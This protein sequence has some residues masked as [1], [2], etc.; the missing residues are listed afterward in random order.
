MNKI[1]INVCKSHKLKSRSSLDI[2]LTYVCEKGYS[3]KYAYMTKYE[4]KSTW[5]NYV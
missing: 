2:N 3:S 1:M 5:V 4:N